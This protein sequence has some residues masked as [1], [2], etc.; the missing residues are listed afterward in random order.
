MKLD[1]WLLGVVG[2]FGLMGAFSGALRQ[3]AQWAGLAAAYLLAKPLAAALGPALAP[4][5]GAWG[6]FAPLGAAAAS[7]PA[8]YLAVGTLC[9]L[10]LARLVPAGE[11]TRAD[12][13][14]GLAMGAAKGGA[15]VFVL[16]SVLVSFEEPLAKAGLDLEKQ[17]RGSTAV[18]FARR[19]DLF[20]SLK[21]PALDS[22]KRLAAARADPAAALALLEDPKIKAALSD[23]R[24]KALTSDPA[25]QKAL[26]AGDIAAVVGD[27]RVQKLL[28][29]PELA[30]ALEGVGAGAGAAAP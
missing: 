30:K 15:L 23:P 17:T 25:L 3:V 1:L 27:P 10:A 8:V 19:R 14:A 29:D 28:A 4:R 22:A 24:L 21:V 16:L 9:R 6:A 5:L 12:R 13:A 11:K 20:A 26:R 18:A 2:L 7:M